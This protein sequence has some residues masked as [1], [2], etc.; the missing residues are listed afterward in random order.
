MRES[1][2]SM[3][4][5]PPPFFL[6]AQCSVWFPFALLFWGLC[7]PF[8]GPASEGEGVSGLC[9]RPECAGSFTLGL[10]EALEA[11]GWQEREF[12]ERPRFLGD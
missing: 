7:S 10:T 11:G 1:S 3:L 6:D 5:P 12:M 8:W 2:S 9:L 4:L